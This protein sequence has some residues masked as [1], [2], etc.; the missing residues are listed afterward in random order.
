MPSVTMIGD[1]FN[2]HS[3]IICHQVNCRGIMGAGLALNIRKKYPKVYDDYM[4]AYK[5]GHLDLGNIVITPVGERLYIASICGQ[6]GFGRDKRMVYTD[7]TA[8]SEGLEKVQKFADD[9][10]VR[11]VYVPHH[12]GCGLANGA[13]HMML[14]VI[15]MYTTNAIII[16]K[17]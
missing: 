2:I 17:F 1:I 4:A 11:P 15:H 7:Y 10:Q 13:W 9:N 6:D 14:Q 3:G 16:E 8:V 12:M 5:A